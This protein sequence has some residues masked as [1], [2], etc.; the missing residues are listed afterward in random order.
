MKIINIPLAILIGGLL[1]QVLQ[2]YAGLPENTWALVAWILLS[3]GVF[4]ML[5]KED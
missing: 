4:L 1:A 3:L 5:A 2:V